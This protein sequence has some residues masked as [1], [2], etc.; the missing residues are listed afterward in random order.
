MFKQLATVPI[1]ILSLSTCA[2]IYACSEVFINGASGIA[3]VARNMD[4]SLNTGDEFAL[5]RVGDKNTSNINMPQ[6][7]AAKPFA[8]TTKYAF[9]GQDAFRTYNI[10]DGVN[11]QGVYVGVLDLPNITQY[12]DYNPHD[13]RPELSI[14]NIPNYVLGTAAT[15]PEALANLAKVQMVNAAFQ[16]T[17]DPAVFGSSA[18]HM[19]MHDK[20]GNGAL[21]EW[22]KGPSNQPETDIYFYKSGSKQIIEKSYLPNQKP[23]QTIFKNNIMSVLTNSPSYSWHLKNTAQYNYVFSGNTDRK[24]DGQYMNGSGMYGIP[25]DWT[26]P[27][28]FV[29]ASQLIRLMPT[30][31]NEAQALFLANQA[32]QTVVVPLGSNIAATEWASSIDLQTST[33]YFW[34][35]FSPQPVDDGKI[36]QVTINPI[37][38]YWQKYNLAAIAN[39]AQLPQGWRSAQVVPGEK[40]PPGGVAKI[41]QMVNSPTPGKMQYTIRFC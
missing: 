17:D 8:W 31:N 24:W 39:Q 36:M 41:M 3:A 13:K 11:S 14:A 38:N 25:G 26:P 6:Q 7:G 29:R 21:I 19:I 16:I 22:I 2:S 35:M 9:L 40:V 32:W 30:P 5:G 15:V 18:V 4:L 34:K 23:R 10:V 28:R 12:P 27:S 33:Y 37:H 20:A 1:I